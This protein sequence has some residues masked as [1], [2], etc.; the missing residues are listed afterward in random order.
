MAKRVAARSAIVRAAP[1]RAPQIIR[2]SAPRAT[3]KKKHHRRR[4]GSGGHAL[5]QKTLIGAAVGGAALGFIDK[6]FPTLPTIPMLGRAGTIAVIAYMLAG[7]GGGTFGGI[8]R[9]VALAGA[10]VAGYE[11]GGTGKVSGG[12]EV[13]GLAPQ[14]SGRGYVR[15]GTSASQV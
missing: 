10:A 3:T 6:Q 15:G 1:M 8:A 11:L 4:G 5:N 2:V 12:D 7:K 14:V 9:D 13:M